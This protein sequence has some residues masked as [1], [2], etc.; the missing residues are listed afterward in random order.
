MQ[1]YIE[2][3]NLKKRYRDKCV[4]DIPE[5]SLEKGRLYGIVGQNGAGKTTLFRMIAK[6]SYP[7]E[8]M[9]SYGQENGLKW[10]I[11]IEGPYLDGDL[12]ARESLEWIQILNHQ[13]DPKRISEI[14]E[15]VGLSE[16]R[17]LKAK[18]FSLG[19]KQRLGLAGALIHNPDVLLLDEP[20]NGLDPNGIIEMRN[21]IKTLHNRGITI[22]IASHILEELNKL[23]TDFIFIRK[24]RIV[25]KIEASQMEKKCGRQLEIST[26]NMEK[27]QE[28]LE[29]YFHL[30]IESEGDIFLVEHD[31]TEP[32]TISRE[33]LK[34]QIALTHFCQRKRTLE[35]YYL[36]RM[37]E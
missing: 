6:L 18:D 7:S 4:V 14:L 11:M 3:K 37:E 28:I 10:G 8:G 2:L 21:I 15:F 12:T 35:E 9:I 29:D 23:A 22:I 26:D 19:M 27:T 1:H 5:L 20:M 25:E 31:G 36:E 17:T 24:G 16:T 13:K 34:N 30:K 32:L 33:L